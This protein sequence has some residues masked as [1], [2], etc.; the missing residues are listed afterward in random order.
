MG[1]V[2]INDAIN[3]LDKQ[4][5][6]NANIASQTNDIAT[7][8]DEIAKLILSNANEKEFIGKENVK[9]TTA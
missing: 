7:Q 5:Q 6:E 3:S 2:Q 4:T 1:I 9:E 8:T